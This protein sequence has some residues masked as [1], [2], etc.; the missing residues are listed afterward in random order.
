MPSIGIGNR[1]GHSS[2]TYWT[3][4]KINDSCL[5]FASHPTDL[6]SKVVATHLPNQV[7]GAIDFLT[8]TGSGLNARYRTPD[9]PTYRTADS[10]NVFWKTDA[11]ESTCDGNRLIGYDFPRILVKYLN[12]SP[13][14]IQWIAILKPGIV[15]T[16]GMRDAFDL[17]KWW[18]NTLSAHGAIKGNRNI[19]QSIWTPESVTDA[20]SDA[21]IA[22]MVVQPNA[23]TKA[24]VNAFFVGLK[25][26]GV[27]S[28]I[29]SFALM[30]L[31]TRQASYLNIK[32]TVNFPDFTFVGTE[33]DTGW[34][35]KLGFYIAN[36]NACIN[37]KFIPANGINFTQNNASIICMV[38]GASSDNWEGAIDGDFTKGSVLS[39][40]VGGDYNR[41]NS[42]ANATKILTLGSK[43]NMISRENDANNI[44]I[45]TNG[46]ETPFTV[47]SSGRTTYEYYIGGFNVGGNLNN[48]IQGN[49]YANYGFASGLNAT[50]R[51]ALDARL[52]A[53][54]TAIQ[55]AF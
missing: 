14:T 39:L 32:G 43:V 51:A 26:D 47:A 13:Y 20:D 46:A 2:S 52:Q 4:R 15:V 8:V 48:T 41:L 50:K 1:I 30:N 12:V 49:T 7:T 36:S 18:D 53:F 23:A 34:N 54:N 45:R 35:A 3:Q 28:E 31:H 16:N 21:Y 55:T 27:W 24:L 38:S 5:F 42:T 9:N 40:R 19:G 22:R 44:I 10:D 11:S 33:A 17:S 25:A 6:L 29:D 37:S